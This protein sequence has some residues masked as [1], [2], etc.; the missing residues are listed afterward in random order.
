MNEA[1]LPQDRRDDSPIIRAAIIALV[2]FVAVLP[3]CIALAPGMMLIEQVWLAF[4]SAV[5]ATLSGLFVL[6]VI[7][8]IA[9]RIHMIRTTCSKAVRGDR[10]A[11]DRDNQAGGS[12]ALPMAG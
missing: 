3:V 10:E 6:G 2:L 7:H 9:R 8:E 4:G 1:T 11:R 5:V 12:S